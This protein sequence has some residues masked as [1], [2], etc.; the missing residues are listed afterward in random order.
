MESNCD[1]DPARSTPHNRDRS[2]IYLTRMTAII[3]LVDISF[4][5]LTKRDSSY[6]RPPPHS[7]MAPLY[8][9]PLALPIFEIHR[10]WNINYMSVS[11]DQV[12]VG[13]C[14]CLYY[15]TDRAVHLYKTM[16][17]T[18]GSIELLNQKRIASS[19]HSVWSIGTIGPGTGLLPS[20]WMYEPRHPILSNVRTNVRKY[21]VMG[22]EHSAWKW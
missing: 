19:E 20:R 15:P 3:V 17:R 9:L 5:V 10:C 13:L 7:V 16:N 21:V 11:F 1:I 18:G 22:L 14:H 12:G 2:C 6:S 8:F 4:V